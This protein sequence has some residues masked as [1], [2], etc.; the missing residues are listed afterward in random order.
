MLVSFP[1]FVSELSDGRGNGNTK[2]LSLKDE[3]RQ[4]TLRQYGNTADGNPVRSKL[5][6]LG[7]FMLIITSKS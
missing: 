5:P 7:S 6:P 3:K 4:V 1:A 2:I